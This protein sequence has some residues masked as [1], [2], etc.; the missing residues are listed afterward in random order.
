MTMYYYVLSATISNEH[1]LRTR[2]C[3]PP[4]GPRLTQL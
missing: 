3:E 4:V 2:P 1:V